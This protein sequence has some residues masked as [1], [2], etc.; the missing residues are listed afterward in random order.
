MKRFILTA[1][2][3][4]A[5]LGVS[6]FANAQSQDDRYNNNNG[7]GQYENRDDR[8]D[9]GQYEEPQDGRDEQGQY[10]E[11]GRRENNGQQYGY[12][13]EDRNQRNGNQQGYNNDGRDGQ[14]YGQR[15]RVQGG[16]DRPDFGAHEI[17]P[18]RAQYLRLRQLRRMAMADGYLTYRERMMLAREEDKLD[19]M[20]S[21]YGRF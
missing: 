5:L 15:P 7:N 10:E 20:R 9:E 11:Q 6:Q 1:T 3:A 16:I 12:N 19:W 18:V 4:V 2:I 14:Y 21:R 8:G 13:N 17:S